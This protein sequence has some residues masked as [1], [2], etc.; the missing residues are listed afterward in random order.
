MTTDKQ[1]RTERFD[2]RPAVP[3][4]QLT[5]R[6]ASAQPSGGAT[7]G[8]SSACSRSRISKREARGFLPRPIFG[9]VSGGSEANASLRGNRDAFDEIRFRAARSGQHARPQPEDAPSS[10][11][12]YDLPF[13]FAADG[14]HVARGLPTATRCSPASQRKLTSR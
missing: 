6:P 13:G 14:R 10:G 2:Q 11:S 8:C 3:G 12:V 7:R 4:D 9:Y 1:T 5:E